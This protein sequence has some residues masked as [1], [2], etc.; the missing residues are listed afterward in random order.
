M[1]KGVKCGKCRRWIA[2]DEWVGEVKDDGDEDC[3][4]CLRLP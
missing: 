3:T 1:R 2:R 4:I